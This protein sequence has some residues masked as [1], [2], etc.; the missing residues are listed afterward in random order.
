MEK[1]R[2]K[3]SLLFSLFIVFNSF[4]LVSS[5]NQIYYVGDNKS[6]LYNLLTNSGVELIQLNSLNFNIINNLPRESSV[7]FIAD[8]YPKTKVSI[9]SDI[10]KAIKNNP[11]IRFFVEFPDS[12]PNNSYEPQKTFIGD[13]ERGVIVSDFFNDVLPSMSLI[14]INDCHLIPIKHNDPIIVYGKVAGF[15]NAVYGI[16][17]T[18][19]YPI[20]VKENNMLISTTSMSN[21]SKGR[22]SPNKSWELIWKEVISWLLNN[23]K[24]EFNDWPHDP[25][26]SYSEID[27]LDDFASYKSIRKGTEWF[28]NSGLL[29]HP[30][31]KDEWLEYQGDGKMPIGPS[32]GHDKLTGDGT[33]GI[34]EGH[35]SSIN[36][37]GTQKY[38]YW[39]RSDVQGEA[40][41]ALAASGSLLE[42]N[43]Y[44]DTSEKLLDFLFYSSG[45]RLITNDKAKA[46]YG[47]LGWS[48]TH[49][50]VI[51][52]DDNARAILGAIGAS[53]YLQ[54]ERWNKLI[55]E[56]ILANFRTTSKFGFQGKWLNSETI[57]VNGFESYYNS[58]VIRVQP[59]FESWMLSCYIW[60]YDKTGYEPLLEKAKKGIRIIMEAYPEDWRWTNGIQQERARM[61][62][63][64]A[65]LLRIEENEEYLNWLT[66]IVD[67]LLDYQQPNGALIEMMGDDETLASYGRT[68]SNANYGTTEAPLIF[69]NGDQVSDM[70]YTS[71]FALFTLNEAAQVT[72][73]VRYINAVNNL[74][75]FLTRVQVKSEKHRDLDGAWFRAFDFERWDYWAS[76]ADLG[77]GAWCTLSGWIQSWIVA[78]KVLV[79]QHNSFWEQTGNIKINDE[80]EESLWML[81]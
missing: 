10:Y 48:Y 53:S 41:F 66:T 70:L 35:A 3:T 54:N 79:E 24:F 32:V 77:W 28:Y 12:F 65:W 51:Y 2:I 75:E 59:H 25:S 36:A 16:D 52:A 6:D 33:M 71:N 81:D 31:W 40:A 56:N 61:I 68:K 73:N 34:L 80:F 49:P 57:D 58:E 13:I 43:K 1:D 9:S 72:G 22:Y 76:N 26:P 69:E 29:L 23:D 4:W 38:R 17:N 46:S 5:Q 20:L 42:E 64:L 78:T 30:S 63:P 27:K 8:N 14:G 67:D 37:D 19:T 39:I 55:V 15:D 47:L 18:E 74:S 7:M 11:N 62:L 44:N 60:L 21:F 45:S 50:H